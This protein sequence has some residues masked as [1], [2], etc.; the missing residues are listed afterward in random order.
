MRAVG[1]DGDNYGHNNHSLNKYLWCAYCEPGLTG[2]TVD[3]GEQSK[4]SS[5]YGA[6][7]LVGQRD[8]NI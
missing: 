1:C 2:S 4:I 7:D 3:R 8:N 6:S 5:S